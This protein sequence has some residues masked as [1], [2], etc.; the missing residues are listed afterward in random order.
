MRCPEQAGTRVT[1]GA[2]E[3]TEDAAIA[4]EYMERERSLSVVSAVLLVAEQLCPKD[5]DEVAFIS[6][7]GSVD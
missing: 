4:T 5:Q 6:S 2:M 1:E 3:S 7:V